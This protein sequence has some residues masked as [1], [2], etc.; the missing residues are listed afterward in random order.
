[1]PPT[2]R[3]AT[4]ADA[5]LIAEFNTLLAAESEDVV[6]APEKI[7]AGVAAVLADPLK[8]LYYLAEEGGQVVGQMGVTYEY[9]D[10]RDGW[11]WWI[12]SVYVRPRHRRQGV[13][14]ALYEHVEGQA[15]ADPTVVGLRLYVEHENDVAR[16]TYQR[17][18]LTQTGYL[19][20]EKGT[21]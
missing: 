13:F 6:L 11:W 14:R 1:M 4:P 20:M 18:G 19:V 9:S 21:A 15:R 17:L 7:A 3:R 5:A 8:G 16:Q 10:W 12:Q 2:I